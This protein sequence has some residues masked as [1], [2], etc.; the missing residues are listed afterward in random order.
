MDAGLCRLEQGEFSPYQLPLRVECSTSLLALSSSASLIEQVGVTDM[1]QSR[2]RVDW[3]GD[4]NLYQGFRE[5]WAVRHLDPRISS[6]SFD[7]E[8][9]QARWGS[10]KE[11]LPRAGAADSSRLPEADRAVHLATPATIAAPAPAEGAVEPADTTRVGSHAHRLPPPPS[12]PPPLPSSPR[13]A[14]P[15]SE[16]R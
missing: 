13:L 16:E 4:R 7:F 2:D 15:P 5:F 14:A 11:R 6:E 12:D 8:N 9:W 10:L 1:E 3:M